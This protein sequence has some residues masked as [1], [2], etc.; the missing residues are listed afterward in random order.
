MGV[1]LIKSLKISEM[2]MEVFVIKTL[3]YSSH[4]EQL[5]YNSG[6]INIVLPIVGGNR[7]AHVLSTT[8]ICM[9]FIYPMLSF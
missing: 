3:K 6:Y 2:F 9:S 5:Q 8:L 1:F 4:M 7:I